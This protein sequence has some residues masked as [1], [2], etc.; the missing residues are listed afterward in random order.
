MSRCRSYDAGSATF[1]GPPPRAAGP[2]LRLARILRASTP[3]GPNPIKALMACLADRSR[4]RQPDDEPTPSAEAGAR[5]LYRLALSES[6]SFGYSANALACLTDE[7]VNEFYGGPEEEPRFC[8]ISD[9]ASL[10]S[11][12]TISGLHFVLYLWA[13]RRGAVR[14]LDTRCLWNVCGQRSLGSSARPRAALCF[15]LHGSRYPRQCELALVPDEEGV[16]GGRDTLLQDSFL[17][18]GSTSL[19]AAAADAAGRDNGDDDEG[20]AGE[21]PCA[22]RALAR[23]LRSA[24][25]ARFP[26]P[27]PDGPAGWSLRDVCVQARRA[28]S[29]LGR[30]VLL[31][32]RVGYRGTGPVAKPSSHVF[33]HVACLAAASAADDDDED[34]GQPVDWDSL[35][36]VLVGFLDRIFLADGPTAR[37]VKTD[38]SAI[39][40]DIPAV[41]RRPLPDGLEAELRAR[42]RAR[43]GEGEPPAGPAGG[44]DDG[45]RPA[46]LS[47]CPCPLCLSCSQYRRNLDARG[48]QKLYKVRPDLLSL[49]RCLGLD[50]ADNLA[51]V[52][53]CLRLSV[54][55]MDLETSTWAAGSKGWR[56]E[57]PRN[58]ET[59][60]FA[61]LSPRPA[62]GDQELAQRI[63]LIGH[64]DRHLPAEV[65]GG[66]DE[67]GVYKILEAPRSP[68]GVREVVHDYVAY[69][70]ARQESLRAEKEDLLAP[71]L[72]FA[73]EYKRAFF[74][75]CL[76]SSPPP[77]PPRPR[78][79][80]PPTDSED[81]PTR[82]GRGSYSALQKTRSAW[83]N[84][85]LGM[86]ERKLRRL[87]SRY[88]VQ[89]FNAA[90]FDLPL[91]TGHLV[92][93]PHTSGGQW[94]ITRKGSQVTGL[95]FPPRGLFFRGE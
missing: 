61:D 9:A 43:E 73:L 82:G 26:P 46:A 37:V 56:G 84:S 41:C 16:L 74:S 88:E 92:T 49:L 4:P 89:A 70:L 35:P 40:S 8:S 48:A 22:L 64:Y 62:A 50:T 75:Y 79:T 93:N 2:E 38:R 5:R 54:A 33:M 80:P 17:S 86:L 66:E 23:L 60:P 71:L 68:D 12:K 29:L 13:G 19:W 95:S 69:V 63:L 76:S 34:G 3:L 78:P 55:G 1:A 58:R 10:E 42:E 27:H 14:L 28:R 44:E 65:P 7:V 87:A 24:G 45:R 21:R 77:R 47:P 91:L 25:P 31:A 36:V 85:L 57:R 53:R 11:L 20:G 67:E 32:V 81:P 18:S 94:R 15:L 52:R 72:L 39:L 90:G 51:R 59:V 83:D 30:D 6:V